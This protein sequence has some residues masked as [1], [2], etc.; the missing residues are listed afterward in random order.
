[1]NMMKKLSL[2]SAVILITAQ[3]LWAQTLN[4]GISQLY[5]EHFN[6][7]TETLTKVYNT[8][9]K[10]PQAIY[11]LG[12]AY[13][14]QNNIDAAKTLYQKALNEG[15]ND[16]YIWI[17]S[18]H[19]ELLNKGDINSAKQKF[20]QAITATKTRKGEDADI[21][22]AIG[23]AN[24][25][26]G[27]NIGDPL[28]AIEKLKRATERDK[29]NADAFLYMGICYL[30]LGGDNGGNAVSAFNE[31][32]SRNPKLA[33][34]KFRIGRVY[35]SQK[36]S[37]IF[38]PTFEEAIT[39]DPAYSPSYLELYEYYAE[40]E[41]DKAKENIEK[42]IQ[43]SEHDPRNDLFY[44]DYLFRVGKYQESLNKA[45]EIE[46]KTTFDKL[47]R[48]LVVFAYNYD[49][50]KDS[51]K[52]K[53]YIE[54]FFATAPAEK[55]KPEDYDFAGNVLSRIKGSEM[56]AVQYL[57]KAMANDTSM[58]NKRNYVTKIANMMGSAKMYR[59]QHRWFRKLMSMKS[60]PEK[61]D[62]YYTA[63]AAYNAEMY[64]QADSL[65]DIFHAKFP[66][67]EFGFSFK[68][69]VTKL[70][71]VD[72][73]KGLAFE[74]IE[75]YNTFLKK[76]L[77]NNKKKIIYNYYYV[78]QL[79][80]DKM[81]DYPKALAILNKILEVD[82]TDAFAT[83]AKPVLEN[84]IKQQEEQAKKTNGGTKS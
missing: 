73:T 40:R 39:M 14:T 50:L 47:P 12:Q 66:E 77:A 30:K 13:L 81:K 63:V 25:D 45:K 29:N 6:T 56:M 11:W 82:P 74:P 64:Q 76:D 3:S 2:L 38:I 1:M 26:G 10:D 15:V 54:K 44:A 41:F 8:N 23:R 22:T 59:E 49:R 60:D 9:P 71:D 18:G 28:Y 65:T 57:E 34:A 5:Y 46:S 17:G 27:S 36:N 75:Q 72:S 21:L 51:L 43:Y 58:V 7:A 52:A 31:A 55:I 33:K 70:L 48:L 4:D 68:V 35:V 83:Q 67:E 37:A 32:V 61:M 80:A 19:V 79:L 20:E 69:R 42:Y 53:E 78:A 84:A 16:P 62:I 24:A